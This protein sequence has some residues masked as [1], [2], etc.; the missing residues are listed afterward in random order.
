MLYTKNRALFTD[1]YQLTM[2]QGYFNLGIN[3]TATFDLFFRNNPFKGGYSVA[4]GIPL[5]LEYLKNFKFEEEELEYLNSQ[6]LFTDDFIQFLSKLTFTGTVEGVLE[7][8]LVFPYVPILKVTAPIIEAQL[9]ETALL[10]IIN[11]STLIATKSARVT[12]AA[13]GGKVIEFGLR[14]AQADSAYVGT[15]AALVGG[16]VGTSF[17]QGGKIWGC[18]IIGTHAHSWVQA[19]KSEEEA[20]KAYADV[21]P[22]KCLLLIDTYNV[23]ESGLPNAIKIAKYLKS[24]GKKILGVRIDSGDLAYLSIEVYRAFVKAG[25]PDISIVLSNELDEYTINSI[26]Q[27]IREQINNHKTD[28][29]LYLNTIKH[30]TYGVGT[31]LI[32]GGRQSALGGVYKLVAV[33][34]EPRIKVSENPAKTINPGSKKVWRLSNSEGELIADVIALDD[35]ETPNPNEWIHHP[36]DHFK[37]FKI[38]DEVESQTLLMELMHNGKITDTSINPLNWKESHLRFERQ[39]QKLNVT[40]KRLMNPHIYKVSLTEKLYKLKKTLVQ[41]FSHHP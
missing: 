17:V 6:N 26:V 35:E 25:F 31:H 18:P 36:I 14:R 12:N 23:L 33:N 41:K 28:K 29:N 15:R 39:F 19:F 1:L 8:T 24:K 4:C 16:C 2:S 22:D 27:Q 7:G 40:Y 34:G 10:N 3:D 11:Y 32:T 37:K 9:V 30:L 20:F 21:F 38:P 5:A 13:K